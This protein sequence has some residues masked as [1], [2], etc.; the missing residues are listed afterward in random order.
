MYT[1]LVEGEDGALKTE[2]KNNTVVGVKKLLIDVS[3]IIFCELFLH[4]IM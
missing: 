4:Y 2:D 1:E 3:D